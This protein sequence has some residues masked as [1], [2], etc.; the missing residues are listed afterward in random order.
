MKSQYDNTTSP[1]TFFVGQQVWFYTPKRCKGLSKKLLHNYH[2][3]YCIVEK[4]SPVNFRLC[5]LDNRLLS[6]P[7]HANCLKPYLDPNDR[8]IEPPVESP[9]VQT[10][11]YLCDSDLPPESFETERVLTLPS[12]SS[13][14]IRTTQTTDDNHHQIHAAERIEH[15]RLR[16]GKHMYLVKWQGY[17]KRH[18][19][20]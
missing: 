4:L 18:N 13:T 2:D 10:E 1:V 16:Q 8:P 20:W 9:K 14:N 5:T 12:T 7:V 17:S 19:T 11:P 3:S 15:H 6:V